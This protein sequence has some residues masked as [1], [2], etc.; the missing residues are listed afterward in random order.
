MS[1]TVYKVTLTF[2][3]TATIEIEADSI[4]AARQ[5]TAALT[6]ADLARSSQTDILSLKVAA[7][8]VTPVSALGGHDDGGE[9]ETRPA[10][11]RPSGW[12]RPA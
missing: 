7:R 10:R 12:Y 11:P 5:E 2:Q 1:S 3:G 9:D 8:E 4:E 6:M